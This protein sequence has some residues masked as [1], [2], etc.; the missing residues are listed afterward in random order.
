M[1]YLV[2]ARLRTGQATPL[3]K[4]IEE[5]NLGVGSIAG[6]E[7]LRDMMQARKLNDGTVCWIEVCFCPT[8]LQ[9]ERP[10]WEEHFELLQIK[11]A[12]NRQECRDLN[13]SEPW[14]CSDCDCTKRLKARMAT[15]STPFLAELRAEVSEAR[16]TGRQSK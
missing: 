1:R 4:A 11:H 16:V 12:H 3:V 8:P 10:Y 7:Y 13:G 6:G 15:R 5:G 9:E 14:A 2:R